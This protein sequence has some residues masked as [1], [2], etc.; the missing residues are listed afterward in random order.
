[1]K[2]LKQPI[3]V[4]VVIYT[5]AQDVLLLQRADHPGYW[6][7]VTG[8]REDDES[9]LETARREVL[10]ETGI[11]TE[12]HLLIDTHMQN[13]YEIYPEW[14]Y[15]YPLGVTHNVEHVFTLKL[16]ERVAVQV[17]PNEHLG[18]RWLDWQQAAQEVFSPSNCAAIQSLFKEQN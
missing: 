18:Y 17:S 15:R 6:Q 14:R 7:S 9:L 4:L 3:S 11:C 16:A 10:E 12:Q 2:P 1:M 5:A 13:R 8:S